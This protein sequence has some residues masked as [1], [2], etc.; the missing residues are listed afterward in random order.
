MLNKRISGLV[1]AIFIAMTGLVLSPSAWAQATTSLHGAVTD[2]SGASIPRAEIT[3]INVETNVSR[4]TLT[5]SS[6]VYNF[7]AVQPGNYKLT[8]KATGFRTYVRTGIEL[9]VNLPATVNI[10][11]QVGAVSQNVTVSGRAPELNTTDASMGKNMGVTAINQLPLRA[12]NM[13]LLLSYQAGVI[14]TGGNE[15]QYM[16]NNYDTRAGSVNGR[17]VTRITSRSTV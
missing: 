11:M 10:G 9:Q 13:P 3:L 14:F 16:L 17:E 1:F 4:Q 8:V 5:T 7:D 2:P 15:S 12:E 6:G